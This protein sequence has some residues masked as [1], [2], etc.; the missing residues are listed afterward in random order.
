MPKSS[1]ETTAISDTGL[2]IT[3]ANVYGRDNTFVRPPENHSVYNL[4]GRIAVEW[5]YLEHTLDRIIWKLSKVPGSRGACLTAQMMGVWPRF[6]A[7]EALL[8]QN[9]DKFLKP[10]KIINS[11]NTLGQQCQVISPH[12]VVH[13]QC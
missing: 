3:Q 13:F 1:T 9:S 7:I 6:N 2:V 8:T 12:R 4:I 11:M 10:E 5:S